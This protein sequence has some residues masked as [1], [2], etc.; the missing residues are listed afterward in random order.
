MLSSTTGVV[1]MPSEKYL[2]RVLNTPKMF[3]L[4]SERRDD[5][6]GASGLGTETSRVH[7]NHLECT[8]ETQTCLHIQ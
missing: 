5:L 2:L 4:V 1:N 3:A 7:L 8:D 6:V